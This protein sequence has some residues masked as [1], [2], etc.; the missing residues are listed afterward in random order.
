MAGAVKD[1]AMVLGANCN[2]MVKFQF[3]MQTVHADDSV[4]KPSDVDTTGHSKLI[5]WKCVSRM[6]IFYL[7]IGKRFFRKLTPLKKTGQLSRTWLF[8]LPKS[9]FLLTYLV[10]INANSLVVNKLTY[11]HLKTRRCVQVKPLLIYCYSMY[12]NSS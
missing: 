1:C 7:F 8:Q 12:Y 5:C 2:V 3:W 11:Y 4:V 6:I 9:L 10:T